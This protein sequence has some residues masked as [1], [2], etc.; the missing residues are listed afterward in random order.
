[1]IVGNENDIYWTQIFYRRK[2]SFYSP[3]KQ[4]NGHIY[5]LKT[6]LKNFGSIKFNPIIVFNDRCLIRVNTKSPV[7][8]IRDL[9][10]TIN[11]YRD[12]VLLEEDVEKIYSFLY[13]FNLSDNQKVQDAHIKNIRSRVNT[14]I[15]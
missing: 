9:I 6:F 5:A 10:I 2:F 12:E 8:Y 11:S 14:K 4:N 15:K 3:I 7:I 13:A 1:M